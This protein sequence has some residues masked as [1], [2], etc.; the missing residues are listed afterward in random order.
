MRKG[1]SAVNPDWADLAQGDAGAELR[2][3]SGTGELTGIRLLLGAPVVPNTTSV[4]NTEG[5]VA[6]GAFLPGAYQ[7][8][9]GA[10]AG[11]GRGALRPA[12]EAP[13]ARRDDGAARAEGCLPGAGLGAA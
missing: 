8:A 11:P 7:S 5:W 6:G 13:G 1:R 2:S 3:F 10:L 9:A 4:S 12:A